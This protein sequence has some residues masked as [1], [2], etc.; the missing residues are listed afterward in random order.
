VVTGQRTRARTGVQNAGI[1][2]ATFE[3]WRWLCP[4][5]AACP[6]APARGEGGTDRWMGANGQGRRAHPTR[7]RLRKRWYCSCSP[8]R[9]PRL[10]GRDRDGLSGLAPFCKRILRNRKTPGSHDLDHDPGSG[11]PRHHT[12]ARQPTEHHQRIQPEG[13]PEYAESPPVP[14]GWRGL[15]DWKTSGAR[16]ARGPCNHEQ[17]ALKPGLRTPPRTDFFVARAA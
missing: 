5:H 14:V 2:M 3:C 9:R 17:Q 1:H 10:D 6:A 15:T 16:N 7:Q 11:R 8:R 13:E 4:A 12:N